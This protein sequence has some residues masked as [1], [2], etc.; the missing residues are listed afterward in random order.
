[1]ING[2]K[3]ETKKEKIKFLKLNE[4]E[5]KYNTSEINFDER[6]LQCLKVY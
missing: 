6:N 2:S 4:I 1:M 3:D 5:N